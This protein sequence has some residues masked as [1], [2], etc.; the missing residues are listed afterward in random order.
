M[1]LKYSGICY[2]HRE[3]LLRD[4]PKEMLDISPK[5]TVPVL[6]LDDDTVLDESLDIV[7]WALAQ[8]DPDDWMSGWDQ[9]IIDQNDGPFKQ[10]LDRYKYGVRY[11]GEDSEKHRLAA[12]IILDNLEKWLLSR[13]RSFPARIG[14]RPSL[15]RESIPIA[16]DILIFPFIR[17]YSKIDPKRWDALDIPNL[18]RWLDVNLSSQLFLDVMEKK[19]IWTG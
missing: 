7:R 12:E 3:I 15:R 16:T 4:K 5:G 18:R 11:P 2:E 6:V 1:A 14:V 19:Q 8:N 10:H 13:I 9:A 17:Q